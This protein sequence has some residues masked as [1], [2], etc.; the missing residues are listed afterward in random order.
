MGFD[1][2]F[3]FKKRT[4][5]KVEAAQ[6]NIQWKTVNDPKK[7]VLNQM[8]NIIND[9]AS[10]VT[11]QSFIELVERYK[12]EI[13]YKDPQLDE[14]KRLGL[15]KQENVNLLKDQ[16]Q[17]QL[18]KVKLEQKLHNQENLEAL[19]KLGT[20]IEILKNQDGNINS[21]IHQNVVSIKDQTSNIMSEID[22]IKNMLQNQELKNRLTFKITKDAIERSKSI[23]AAHQFEEE[24]DYL[25]SDESILNDFKV[26]RITQV[27]N[28]AIQKYGD[29]A[30]AYLNPR[31]IL[32]FLK[33]INSE[34]IEQHSQL[35]LREAQ[36]QSSRKQ[37]FISSIKQY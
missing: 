35:R 25:K 21:E 24:K 31:E 4:I 3:E 12:R 23:A 5:D 34:E 37:E 29:Q 26:E 17:Y 1:V 11:D 20:K 18:N 27:I 22:L 8:W 9:M 33:S 16:F 30:S 15:I 6:R 28:E 14:V 19:A 2:L 7:E 13:G 32:D 10:L 36:F